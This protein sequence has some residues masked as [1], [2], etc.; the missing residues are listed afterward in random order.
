[1]SILRALSY[2]AAD[3]ADFT[4]HEKVFGIR[5]TLLV[6]KMPNVSQIQNVYDVVRVLAKDPDRLHRVQTLSIQDT[7]NH[8]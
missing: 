3:L 8:I 1:M 6:T 4:M 2:G 7:L 5:G